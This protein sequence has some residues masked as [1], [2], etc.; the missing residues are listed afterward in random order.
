MNE[1]GAGLTIPESELNDFDEGTGN[2][3]KSGS[4]GTGVPHRLPLKLGPLFGK[5]AGRFA[6]MRG[7]WGARLLV[8]GLV[9]KTERF[10][11]RFMHK[12]WQ[13]DVIYIALRR[14]ERSFKGTYEPPAMTWRLQS[15]IRLSFALP[16]RGPRDRPT[17]D[18]CPTFHSSSLSPSWARKTF[19]GNSFWVAT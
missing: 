10:F 14:V 18:E 1:I 4:E 11:V 5:M 2:R 6:Q 7:E 9:R 13:R 19:S 15:S 17:W 3:A 12:T 8:E 16:E